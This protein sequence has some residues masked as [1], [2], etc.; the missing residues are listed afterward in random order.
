VVPGPNRR[1]LARRGDG[2]GTTR[3]SMSLGRCTRAVRGALH[4]RAASGRR[5][6]PR[7]RS[8]ALLAMIEPPPGTWCCI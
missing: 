7:V 2:R 1:R 8:S 3:P 5:A 6:R 4:P